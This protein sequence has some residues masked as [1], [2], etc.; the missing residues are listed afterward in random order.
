MERYYEPDVSITCKS[1]LYRTYMS[2][3][4]RFYKIIPYEN[5]SQRIKKLY[6][7][8]WQI[9]PSTIKVWVLLLIRL[10]HPH[11]QRRRHQRFFLDNSESINMKQTNRNRNIWN[12]SKLQ[13]GHLPWRK[14]PTQHENSVASNISSNKILVCIFYST[15]TSFYL[16]PTICLQGFLVYSYF[17]ATIFPRWLKGAGTYFIFIDTYGAWLQQLP[18]FLFLW[19]RRELLGS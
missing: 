7:V 18:F 19:I 11:T 10:L 3:R 13:Q 8:K 15:S 14:L 5:F 4:H 6:S 9:Q 12:T 1:H 2:S 17:I 16:L